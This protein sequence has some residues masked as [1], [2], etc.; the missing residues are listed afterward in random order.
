MHSIHAGSSRRERLS[1]FVQTLAGLTRGTV[2]RQKQRTKSR[3]L[4]DLAVTN[5]GHDKAVILR[6]QSIARTRSVKPKA[7]ERRICEAL[8]MNRRHG[9]DASSPDTMIVIMN[10]VVHRC[11]VCG[12]RNKKEMSHHGLSKAK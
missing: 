6:S 4:R 5:V 2:T 10:S 8:T 11:S 1:I 3:K 12:K 7:A 9:K